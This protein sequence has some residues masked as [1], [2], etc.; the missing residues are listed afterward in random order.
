MLRLLIASVCFANAFMLISTGYASN[1]DLKDWTTRYP[2][3]WFY[4]GTLLQL[5]RNT[6]QDK[7]LDVSRLCQKHLTKLLDDAE[8]HKSWALKCK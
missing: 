1:L 7:Q 3:P 6:I 5:F 8:S 4:N 2:R